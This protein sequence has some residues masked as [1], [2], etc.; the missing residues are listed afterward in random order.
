MLVD[1]TPY[2]PPSTDAAP[3]ARIAGRL[4]PV[5]A[6]PALPEIR[7]VGNVYVVTAC[8]RVAMTHVPACYVE[9]VGELR[10][11]YPTRLLDLDGDDELDP[12]ESVEIHLPTVGPARRMS[13]A[14]VEWCQR[15]TLA[16]VA[17]FVR[18]CMYGIPERA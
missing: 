11:V 14:E 7:R 5:A 16:G 13:A 6:Y 8:D 3:L 9:H 1:L 10:A 4:T 18:R 12:G 17:R 15:R 2:V